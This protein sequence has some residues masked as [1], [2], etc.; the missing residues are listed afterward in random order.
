MRTG[1][2]ANHKIQPSTS[3]STPHGMT[4]KTTNPTTNMTTNDTAINGRAAQNT[5]MTTN[6]G[7]TQWQTT[8]NPMIITPNTTTTTIH[9]HKN[10]TVNMMTTPTGNIA[11]AP[12]PL[13]N[14]QIQETEEDPQMKFP[15]EAD[16]RR[17]D[18]A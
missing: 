1:E 11:E 7:T 17:P 10:A 4:M 3:G 14:L 15:P 18:T 5:P 8:I 12:T 16:R 9:A 2:K 6:P 13:I